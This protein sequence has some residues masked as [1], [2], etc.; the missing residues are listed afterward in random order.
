MVGFSVSHS[1][2]EPRLGDIDGENYYFTERSVM[3]EDIAAGRFLEHAKVNGNLYGTSLGAVQDV[4][5][6]GKVCILDINVQVKGYPPPSAAAV[7][8]SAST[9]RFASRWLGRW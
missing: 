9:G 3:E 5:D 6:E 8:F 4:L 1:T 7:N 2:K